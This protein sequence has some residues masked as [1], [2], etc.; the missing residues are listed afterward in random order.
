MKGGD[1]T[2]ADALLRMLEM[3]TGTL[4]MTAA[5]L[6]VAMDPKLSEAIRVGYGSDL[7]CQRL[8]KNLDSFPTIKVVDGLIYMGSRLVV[9]RVGTL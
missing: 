8:R 1:N 3:E 4:K 5:V 9:P 6:S 7:F 2:V